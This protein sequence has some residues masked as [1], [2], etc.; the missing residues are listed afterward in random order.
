[1]P[2]LKRGDAVICIN[3]HFEDSKTNPFEFSK[4]KL[5]KEKEYYTVRE[6]VESS[7][8]IGIRL[9]E[10]VNKKYYFDNIRR[11]EEPIF[12]INRFRLL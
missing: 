11:K 8:G 6:I 2:I 7:Y 1:M 4:I 3:S 9:E 12:D 5:P 10:V